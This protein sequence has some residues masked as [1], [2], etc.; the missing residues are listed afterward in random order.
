MA[1]SVQACKSAK[2][3]EAMRRGLGVATAA[4]GHRKADSGRREGGCIARLCE[5]VC[6][7]G[8]KRC[9][10]RRRKGCEPIASYQKKKEAVCQKEAVCLR[11]CAK[12]RLCAY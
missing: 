5:A 1:M 9:V 12:R 2:A 11:L 7:D 8:E 4:A 3:G 6:R 10:P